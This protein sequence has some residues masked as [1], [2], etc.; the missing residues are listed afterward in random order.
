MRSIKFVCRVLDSVLVL[1]LDK[2]LIRAVAIGLALRPILQPAS[3]KRFIARP[4]LLGNTL[5]YLGVSELA[6]KETPCHPKTLRPALTIA[7][8]A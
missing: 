6:K 8:N 7:R 3:F 5:E 2:T 1:L 4:L